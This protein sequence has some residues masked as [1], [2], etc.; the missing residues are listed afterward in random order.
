MENKTFDALLL[1]VR[2]DID[3]IDKQLLQLFI[4][5]MACS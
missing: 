2:Q 5:R 4:E 1:P 3:R